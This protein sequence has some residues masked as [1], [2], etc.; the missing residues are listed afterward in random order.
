MFKPSE[1]QVPINELGF[2]EGFPFEFG[3]GSRLVQEMGSFVE[4]SKNLMTQINTP[5]SM[6]EV[7]IE[8]MQTNKVV[9]LF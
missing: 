3:L 7:T 6:E 8:V 1:L 9:E 5:K 4:G 2:V